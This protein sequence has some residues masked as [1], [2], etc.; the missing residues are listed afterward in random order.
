MKDSER[1]ND[2]IYAV[3]SSSQLHPHCRHSVTYTV[4][5]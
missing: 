1:I 5:T 2:S 3:L 4:S